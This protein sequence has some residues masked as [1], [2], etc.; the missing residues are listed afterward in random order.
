[1]EALIFRLSAA[2]GSMSESRSNDLYDTKSRPMRSAIIGTLAAAIG[3]D[4][5]DYDGLN[6]LSNSVV[7]TIAQRNI[8]KSLRDYHTIQSVESGVKKKFFS[9]ADALE[10]G[11]G[12][13]NPKKI[14]CKPAT[15]MYMTDIVYD[16]IIQLTPDATISLSD[17]ENSLN[18]PKYILYFGRRCCPLTEP[19]VP[20]IMDFSDVISLV[21]SYSDIRGED[22]NDLDV[23]FIGDSSVIGTKNTQQDSRRELCIYGPINRYG[24]SK[25]VILDHSY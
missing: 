4:R 24:K 22:I 15:K 12:Q 7:V 21:S 18:S 16:I 19:L 5:E 14:H 20:K 8:G 3:I 13:Y 11:S 23:R 6:S 25:T 10:W 1:M 2:M 9:R 17:L